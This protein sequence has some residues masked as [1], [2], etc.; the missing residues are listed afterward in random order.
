MRDETRVRVYKAL[1]SFIGALADGSTLVVH[2]SR[3][4][5]ETDRTQPTIRPNLW[6]LIGTV[7]AETAAMIE[8]L[9]DEA[10]LS[11][12]WERI[13]PSGPDSLD[14]SGPS[15]ATTDD[16]HRPLVSR[17]EAIEAYERLGSDRK[18]ATA[19]GISRTQVRRLRG[20]DV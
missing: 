8:A 1:D 18:A 9:G 20:V 4:V 7:D 15:P 13:T 3:V 16:P 6:Q 19:L 14:G 2:K 17:E 10:T 12:L 5:V 11:R